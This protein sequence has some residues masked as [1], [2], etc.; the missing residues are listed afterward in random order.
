MVEE[1]VVN[2]VFMISFVLMGYNDSY[3]CRLCRVNYEMNGIFWDVIIIV[4]FCYK[5][6]I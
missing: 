1:Y 6:V 4:L 5:I 3:N 2:W